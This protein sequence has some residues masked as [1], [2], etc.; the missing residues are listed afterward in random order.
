MQDPQFR[1]ELAAWV[2]AGRRHTDDGMPAEAL[3]LPGGLRPTRRLAVRTFD[4]GKGMAAHDAKLIDASPVLAVLG[5]HGDTTLDRLAA[6]QALSHVLLRAA[7]DEV[8]AS[9]LNQPV[10]VPELRPRVAELTGR[11][12]VPQLVLRLG[13][14][15]DARPT[16][17]RPVGEILV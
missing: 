11:E 14:G 6:G 12:G 2:H 9:F 13:R 3:A 4:L 17:R 10:E 5:T 7:Q 1:R 15:P 8:S 16:A